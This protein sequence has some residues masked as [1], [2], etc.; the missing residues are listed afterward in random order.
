[1]LKCLQ[2]MCAKYYELR[3]MFYFKKLHS[4]KLARLL[5]T[6]SK[7]TLFSVSFERQQVDK[8][9]NLHKN[10]NMQTLF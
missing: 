8:K 7:F 10:R 6:V 4:S 3:Y 2:I 9:A 5:D 1:M